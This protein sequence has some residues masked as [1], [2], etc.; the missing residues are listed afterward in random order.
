MLNCIGLERNDLQNVWDVIPKEMFS[1]NKE[2]KA[3]GMS[4]HFIVFSFMLTM[5]YEWF[6]SEYAKASD[7]CY[8]E[9]D[10]LLPNKKDEIS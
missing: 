9:F 1:T 7:E 8:K 2:N 4:V 3:Y 10:D 6:T 5:K